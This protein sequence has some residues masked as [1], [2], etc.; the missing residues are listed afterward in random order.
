MVITLTGSNSLALR[1]RLNELVDKFVAEYGELAVEWIDAS[2]HSFETM[3]DSVQ[4][5]PLLAVKRMIIIR[6]PGTNK[7]AAQNIEQ[8]ISSASDSTELII[9]DPEPDKRT[10]YFKTLQQQTRLEQF[11]ELDGPG[12]VKW[13][14]DEA[15]RKNGELSLADAGYLMDRV[16]MNQQLLAEELEKL[17]LYDQHISRVSIDLLTEATPQ[18]K[19]FDLLDSAF[20]G[21]KR[22]AL[23]LYDD[24]RAQK[25]E[26]QAIMA[27]LVWQIHL[28][29]LAKL[30]EKH[31]PA[32]IAKD[33]GLKL[34]PVN[35]AAGLAHKLDKQKLRRMIADLLQIDVQSKTSLIDLDEALKTYIVTL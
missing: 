9:Y 18:G 4:S 31:P 26:P 8:I 2:E 6:E 27:M 22:K 24:Q 30:G 28:L 20:S 34:Y 5:L 14:A 21:D 32:D 7:T 10:A 3:L 23:R 11:S 12:L 17:L 15:K 13:L 16:G 33:S 25:V 35:K 1:Q 19:I 29:T